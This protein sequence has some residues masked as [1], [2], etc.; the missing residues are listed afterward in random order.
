MQID[1]KAITTKENLLNIPW[2]SLYPLDSNNKPKKHF[3]TPKLACKLFHDNLLLIN[4]CEEV[5]KFNF[6]TYKYLL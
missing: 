5:M 1:W 2:E 4:R 3:L 6:N